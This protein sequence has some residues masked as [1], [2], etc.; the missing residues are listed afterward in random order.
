MGY[1]SRAKNLLKTASIVH[2]EY[3]DTFPQDPKILQ[4]LPGI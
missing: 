4:T 2:T 3:G 1:Y